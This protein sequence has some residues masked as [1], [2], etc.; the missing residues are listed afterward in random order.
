MI[1]QN[2]KLQSEYFN[3]L[4]K[5]SKI[6]KI[7]RMSWLYPKLSQHLNGKVLD[8]GCGIGDF[9]DYR[10][11]TV[12]VDI[13]MQAVKYCKS[14]GHEAFQ[15]NDDQLPFEKGAFDGVILDNV[16]EHIADPHALLAEVSRVLKVGGY[17]IVGVPGL[18]GYHSDPDH[19]LFY[20]ASLLR[21][22]ME[23]HNFTQERLRKMPLGISFL[24]RIMRQYCL[25][26]IF[27]RE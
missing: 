25:Y 19:K 23:R 3:Y 26:G 14:K 24:D 16:L 22:V 13:N 21:N 4:K 10:P 27:K 1:D 18:K 11:G 7:Y 5:R 15:M 6:A 8:V 2:E 17:A 12:G 9:L 20:D